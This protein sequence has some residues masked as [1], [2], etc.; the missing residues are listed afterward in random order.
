MAASNSSVELCQ[1]WEFQ[2][3]NGNCILAK[4]R[5]DGTDRCG[6]NSDE[7]YDTAKCSGT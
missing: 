2:C 7:N 3:L 4:Y 6:D 1:P 5:C